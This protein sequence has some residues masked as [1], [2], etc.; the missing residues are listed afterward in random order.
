MQVFEMPKVLG[1][2]RCVQYDMNT[3]ISQGVSLALTRENEKK[4]GNA[5]ENVRE[6]LGLVFSKRVHTGASSWSFA[7]CIFEIKLDMDNPILYLTLVVPSGKGF[8][9]IEMERIAD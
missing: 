8:H 9:F 5:L 2:G 3:V 4:L 1:T 7:R 6:K